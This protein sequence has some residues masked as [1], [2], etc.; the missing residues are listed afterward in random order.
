MMRE[1]WPTV[2]KKVFVSYARLKQEGRRLL[3]ALDEYEQIDVKIGEGVDVV[4]DSLQVALKEEVF[5]ISLFAVLVILDRFHGSFP[6]GHRLL[7]LVRHQR[8][9][10]PPLGKR[11]HCQAQIQPLLP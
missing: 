7:R 1:E 5:E 2:L 11:R 6:S 4:G 9:I 3:L 10:R 8:R